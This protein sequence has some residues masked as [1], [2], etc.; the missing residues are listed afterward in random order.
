MSK[1]NLPF[2]LDERSTKKSD[3]TRYMKLHQR[4][5]G[6]PLDTYLISTAVLP[7]PM[8]ST[9]NLLAKQGVPPVASI[10]LSIGDH[11]QESL[12][13]GDV[14]SKRIANLQVELL[15]N[16]SCI[17]D[18]ESNPEV[19]EDKLFR[20][21]GAT[22]KTLADAE[23][24][25]IADIKAVQLE[26]SERDLEIFSSFYGFN[27][28][29]A[30]RKADLAEKVGVSRERIRQIVSAKT[31]ELHSTMRVAPAALAG[32]VLE[33]FNGSYAELLPN[34]RRTFLTDEVFTAFL[35]ELM[36]KSDLVRE[37]RQMDATD[38]TIQT[39][40]ALNGGGQSIGDFI[41]LL[42]AAQ[43]EGG[44]DVEMLHYLVNANR[45]R[46]EDGKL[47]P[48]KMKFNTSIAYVL[49][50]YP[51]GMTADELEAE[52]RANG[53]LSFTDYDP[54]ER[55][56]QQLLSMNTD[57]H[58]Y[59]Y[60]QLFKHV[61]YVDLKGFEMADIC[62][63]LKA[64]MDKIHQP[65]AY[66]DTLLTEVPELKDIEYMDLRYALSTWG[67]EHGIYFMGQPKVDLISSSPIPA[68]TT[69]VDV[70]HAGI[71]H[72]SKPV[73]FEGSKTF[74]REPIRFRTR[75]FLNKLIRTGRV[76]KSEEG[77]YKAA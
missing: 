48:T 9:M 51:G 46:L 32:M 73:D 45:L 68:G 31:K 25:L 63:K 3:I 50:D 5:A 29:E 55:S 65:L 62:A 17:L 66:S 76:T 56:A 67:G 13:L 34:L 69:Q 54:L 75:E 20:I 39:I 7:R 30:L 47:Y 74:V 44:I 42:S 23:K 77:F 49:N 58:T 43:P 14:S 40:F 16:C 70:L 53:A 61:K 35:M 6:L 1:T 59:H 21:Y 2:V 8:Q 11:N 19:C 28:R 64:A 41:A 10:I 36:G 12:G 33:H 38:R 60:R 15:K 71:K 27:R 4:A 18:G 57:P 72:A 52:I 37:E 22:P 26:C 24:L